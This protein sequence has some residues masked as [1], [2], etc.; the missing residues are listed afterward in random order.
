ME[1]QFSKT[2]DIPTPLFILAYDR[3]R[4]FIQSFCTA[5][6]LMICNIFLET[7]LQSTTKNTTEG[8]NSKYSATLCTN[9]LQGRRNQGDKA[10]G[11]KYFKEKQKFNQ[12]SSKPIKFHIFWAGHNFFEKVHTVKKVRGRFRNF[13]WPSQNIWTLIIVTLDFLDLPTALLPWIAWAVS[14]AGKSSYS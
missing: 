6:L 8:L 4:H 1:G 11:P 13:L 2:F 14:F 10:G 12:W 5:L 9:M 7:P 3:C